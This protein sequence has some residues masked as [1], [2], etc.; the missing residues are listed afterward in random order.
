V[1]ALMGALAAAKPREKSGAHT[2]ARYG[3]QVNTS[4]VKMLDLHEAGHDYRAAFDHFDDLVIFDKSVD[5][6]KIGFYQIKTKADGVVTMREITRARGSGTKPRSFLGK[7]NDHMKRFASVVNCLGFISNLAFQFRL[8]DGTTSNADHH[9]IKKPDLHAD[10]VAHVAKTI[11]ED[12]EG[13]V[14][15]GSEFLVFERTF[16]PLEKQ[17]TH[18]RGRLVEHF[19]YHTTGA[20]NVPISSL[21][22]LLFGQ[23]FSKTGVTQEFTALAD[24][25]D[26]KTLCRSN[27]TAIFAKAASGRRFLDYWSA[28][29]QELTTRGVPL[30]EIIATETDCIRYLRA[31][32]K[33]EAGAMDFN[34]AAKSA[35]L[36]SRAAVDACAHVSELAALLEQWI[37]EAY[38]N[39]RGGVFVEAFE[40]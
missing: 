3:Y 5:P 37:T 16:L 39:R 23:V 30:R 15:D 10:E 25:Y 40:A 17:E 38:D 26:R 22:N 32:A 13:A 19:H 9:V 8:S 33:G 34:A 27:I 11:A 2:M 29:Q 14:A 24:F 18:V 6:S 1:T 36:A 21:Y 35:I 20:E 28:I 7:M 4:I 31:R 12:C